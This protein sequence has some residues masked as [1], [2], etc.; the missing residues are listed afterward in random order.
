MGIEPFE[1]LFLGKS[2]QML[3]VVFNQIDRWFYACSFNVLVS[4][5]MSV[6]N[7]SFILIWTIKHFCHFLGCNGFRQLFD[8]KCTYGFMQ[9]LG[10]SLIRQMLTDRPYFWLVPLLKSR[11]LCSSIFTSVSFPQRQ[12]CIHVPLLEL[13]L[14]VKLASCW[15]WTLNSTRWEL[16]FL[17][18]CGLD[19]DLFSSHAE[20]VKL[21]IACLS[22]F[23]LFLTSVQQSH[24]SQCFH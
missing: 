14:R 1:S 4:V 23:V 3:Q 22:C 7:L 9:F 11:I 2:H 20:A 8:L 17:I 18:K 19:P 24:L 12:T 15:V 13:M 21:L 10:N 5:E 6:M 16:F